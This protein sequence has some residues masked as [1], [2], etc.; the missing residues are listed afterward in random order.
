M[1][2]K[3]SGE[4]IGRCG[5]RQVSTGVKTNGEGACGNA[6][7]IVWSGGYGECNAEGKKE[8]SENK[9]LKTSDSV[10]SQRETNPKVDTQGK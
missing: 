8:R 5:V 7:L 3:S 6:L 10:T 4:H 9:N 1:E 2:W